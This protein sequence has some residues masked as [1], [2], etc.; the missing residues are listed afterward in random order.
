MK[1]PD[2][3]LTHPNTDILAYSNQQDKYIEHLEAENKKLEE[4]NKITTAITQLEGKQIYDDLAKLSKLRDTDWIEKATEELS[5]QGVRFPD[6]HVGDKFEN[7]RLIEATA[8]G[9]I[10]QTLT[11]TT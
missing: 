2:K 9:L 1:R 7:Q 10:Q 5:D 6:I 8:Y 11:E 4:I 3:E